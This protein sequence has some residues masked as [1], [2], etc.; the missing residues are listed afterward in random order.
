V[1]AVKQGALPNEIDQAVR[2]LFNSHDQNW[3]GLV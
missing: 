2:D 3:L 1:A